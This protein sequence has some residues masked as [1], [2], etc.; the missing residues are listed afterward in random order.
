V[1][2]YTGNPNGLDADVQEVVKFL[3]EHDPTSTQSNT[4]LRALCSFR[5][6]ETS[7]QVD[8]ALLKEELIDDHEGLLG[9]QWRA[10][11]FVVE[12]KRETRPLFGGPNGE[13][14][15]E[16][17]W[18]QV[19]LKQYGNANPLLQALKESDAPQRWMFQN[20]EKI[21]SPNTTW[22]RGPRAFPRL[23]LTNAHP[24]N[25]IETDGFVHLWNGFNDMTS[26][27]QRFT[28]DGRKGIFLQPDEVNRLTDLLGL[29]EVNRV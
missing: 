11:A 25:Q 15:I 26:G 8:L 17:S 18:R 24:D 2:V 28:D 6:P 22:V 13:W 19:P 10:T 1:R 3:V 9:Q 20:R 16:V 21:A 14:K 23:L 27:I 12:V 4:E 7:C 29:K 5:V